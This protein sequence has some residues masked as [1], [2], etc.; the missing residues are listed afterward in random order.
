M[1]D[2]DA[3]IRSAGDLVDDLL[4]RHAIRSRPVENAFRTVPRHLFVPRYLCDGRM[5]DS[6]NPSYLEGIYS[7]VVLNTRIAEDGSPTSASSQPFLMAEMIE[8][9][10]LE[11][12]MK[13]LEIGTGTGYNAALIHAV[14]DAK[15]VSIDVQ[16]DVVADAKIALRKAGISDVDVFARDG[17]HGYPEG[18]N[19]DR[20]VATV[21]ITGF[22]PAWFEQLAPGGTILAPIS[23]GGLHFLLH[24]RG[25]GGTIRAQGV[26]QV[27]FMSA[28]GPLTVSPHARKSP[29]PISIHEASTIH[30]DRVKSARERW[31]FPRGDD[32]YSD[33]WV[34]CAA[35]EHRITRADIEWNLGSVFALVVDSEPK[36]VAILPHDGRVRFSGPLGIS[37]A[38]QLTKLIV[39]WEKNG[40]PS[41]KDWMCECSLMG[42]SGSAVLV[43]RNWSDLRQKTTISPDSG[44]NVRLQID[45]RGIRPM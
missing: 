26:E 16:P 23:H 31:P 37:A 4:Y 45:S 25:D 32:S 20:I 41:R 27:S 7:D 14:T 44:P 19:F 3:P 38:S 42:P 21:G 36:S 30:F 34:A 18:A 24:A 9:L 40:R 22:S 1:N 5:V 10:G 35:W 43:P 33:L 12:G 2:P 39:S 17:Y 8:T 13:V 11:R 15:V 6:T 29:P 28:D